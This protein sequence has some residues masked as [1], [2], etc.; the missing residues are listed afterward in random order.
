MLLRYDTA[1]PTAFVASPADGS[2]GAGAS[3]S[4][5]G[6]AQPGSRVAVGAQELAVDGRGAFVGTGTADSGGL[7]VRITTSSQGVHYFVRRA[8]GG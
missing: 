7:A 4:V 1:T 5:S 2:F 8:S 3:V 6:T